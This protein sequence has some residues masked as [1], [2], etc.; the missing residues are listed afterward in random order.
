MIAETI[1]V[2]N[3]MTDYK[4]LLVWKKAHELVLIVYKETSH[5]P[6]EE[7]YGITS[8]FRRAAVSIPTNIAEGAGKFSQKDFA[9]F[10]QIAFGSVHEIEYLNL[11]SSDLDY[12]KDDQS[13]QINSKI[14]EVK[15]MLISLI[16][17]VRA[18]HTTSKL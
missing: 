12:L 7:K 15:A 6:S 18:N 3:T 8:Q 9:Q 14:S 4:K 17:T 13:Q 16:K 10:L 1:T 11:L 5:F 2:N